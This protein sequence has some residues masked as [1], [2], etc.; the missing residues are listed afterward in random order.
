MSICLVC[1]GTCLSVCCLPACLLICMSVDG[2]SRAV[3]SCLASGRFAD[4][5]QTCPAPQVPL[6]ASPSAPLLSRYN[7]DDEVTFQ[8][9]FNTDNVTSR[10][11]SDGTWSASG[12]VCGREFP[13]LWNFPVT[14][15]ENILAL[16]EPHNFCPTVR[17]PSSVFFFL[18]FFKSMHCFFGYSFKLTVY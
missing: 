13:Q 5:Q 6:D 11:L 15:Y 12:Y 14:Q 8:C 10:C 1:L 18:Y 3:K 2:L 16:Y 9:R 7:V 17:C 4:K